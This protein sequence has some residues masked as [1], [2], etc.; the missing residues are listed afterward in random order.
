MEDGFFFGTGEG[1]VVAEVSL[2]GGVGILSAVAFPE[3][4]DESRAVVGLDAADD[5]F[6]EAVVAG[7]FYA[8]GY[9]GFDELG[10]FFGGEVEVGIGDGALGDSGEVFD[11]VGGVF[12]FSDVVEEGHDVDFEG[13][14]A[15]F[16]GGG[17]GEN[18]DGEAML[19]GTWGFLSQ[20]SQEGVMGIE[21]LQEAD[22]GADAEESFEEV[23]EGIGGEA[24]GGVD[25]EEEE[26]FPGEGEGG[27]VVEVVAEVGDGVA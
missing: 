16:A 7:E 14:G 11:E 1:A 19:V 3:V 13:V 6:G 20:F 18:G 4:G 22:V 24:D 2:V 27:M 8:I 23:D 12:E 9:V 5:F 17:F 10:A 26:A 25:V 15:D 21:E